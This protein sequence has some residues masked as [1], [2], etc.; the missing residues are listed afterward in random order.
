MSSC[1]IIS[2]TKMDVLSDHGKATVITGG[3]VITDVTTGE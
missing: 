2:M 3:S 1:L